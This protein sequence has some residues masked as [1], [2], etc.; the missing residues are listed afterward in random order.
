MEDEAAL[1]TLK[2]IETI[3]RVAHR[4]SLIAA[5]DEIRQDATVVAIL[6]S[7]NDW[8]TTSALQAAAVKRGASSERTVLRRL[9]DL[10]QSHALERREVGKNVEYRSTGIF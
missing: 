2:R 7:A 10:V 5:G 1:E 9:G 4:E 3:L 8:K 6:D